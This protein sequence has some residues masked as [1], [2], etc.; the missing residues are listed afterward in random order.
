MWLVGWFVGCLL[1]W[2]LKGGR[3]TA[4]VEYRSLLR[5]ASAEP[6]HTP[7]RPEEDAGEAVGE[8]E[9]ERAGGAGSAA[10]NA[11]EQ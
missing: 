5:Q 6:D 2:L 4:S 10:E 1:A 3:E 8:S 11:E 9:V 7:H